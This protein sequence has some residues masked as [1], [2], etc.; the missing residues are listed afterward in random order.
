MSLMEPQFHFFPRLPLGPR[1]LIW[2]EALSVPR[3]LPIGVHFDNKASIK[4]NEKGPPPIPGPLQ[5]CKESRT[6][7]LKSYAQYFKGPY[8][9]DYYVASPS[10]EY[11]VTLGGL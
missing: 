3:T 10:F 9:K 7:A 1:L 8:M 4:L 5:A 6:L 11:L 2:A